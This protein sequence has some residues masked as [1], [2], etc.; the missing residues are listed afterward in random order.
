MHHF[1]LSPPERAEALAHKW[2][3]DYVALGD[4]VPHQDGPA[5]LAEALQSGGPIPAWL[6]PIPAG[7]AI[8]LY[9]IH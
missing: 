6:E 9:R 7:R 8:R 2:G 1:Y 3:I 4:D 5:S